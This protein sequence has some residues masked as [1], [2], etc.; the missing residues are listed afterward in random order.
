MAAPIVVFAFNRP[1]HLKRSLEALAGNDLALESALTVFCDGPRSEEEKEKTDA[2]RKLCRSI[3]GFKSVTLV[4][5]D[6]NLGCDPSV[7]SGLQEFFGVHSE[8]IVVEDD[9]VFSPNALRWFNT[10]L[11][12]FRDE[13]AV[14]SIAGWSFPGK[15]LPI[16]SDYPYDAYFL[17]RFLGW[18]WASWADRIKRIDWTL[19]DYETFIETPL[20]VKAFMRGGADLP[21]L[22]KV[23]RRKGEMDTWDIQAAYA[24]FKHG[25]LSLAPRFPYATNIGTSGE[26][27]HIRP[28]LGYHP[29]HIDLSLALDVPLLP[30]HVVADERILKSFRK[31]LRILQPSFGLRLARR[32][33]RILS[34]GGKVA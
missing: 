19:A 3:S 15:H 30:G 23:Q 6:E 1:G 16:P 25:Q 4:E 7:S 13:P 8:G 34:Q 2:V 5:R 11:E 10:C 20:L 33:K 9:I 22:L 32:M 31:A 17:P 29:A 26:G 27:T 18:G 14:F 21:D 12:R 24:A 28:D